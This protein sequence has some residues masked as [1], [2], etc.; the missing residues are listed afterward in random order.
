MALIMTGYCTIQAIS[1]IRKYIV[2]LEN[3]SARLSFKYIVAKNTCV[4]DIDYKN[5][6]IEFLDKIWAGESKIYNGKL[7]KYL[8][9]YENDENKSI[10]IFDKIIT[11]HETCMCVWNNTKQ[12]NVELSNLGQLIKVYPTKLD[13]E[14][15][16]KLEETYEQ[17]KIY[18]RMAFDE[19]LDI[20]ERNNYDLR[21]M[22]LLI[23]ILVQFSLQ[24]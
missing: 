2:N 10:F 14:K 16:S 20:N 19:T 7:E 9:E 11:M 24:K 5:Q 13:P 8:K 15:L 18:R 22:L 21:A 12:N 17:F 6:I 1:E 3:D 4:N 23:D